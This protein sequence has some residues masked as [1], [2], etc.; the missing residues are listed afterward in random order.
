VRQALARL[1]RRVQGDETVHATLRWLLDQFVVRPHERIAY[2]K[3]PEFTFRF[4]WDDGRLRFIDNGVGRF[5]RA[6]IRRDSLRRLTYDLGLWTDR[7]SP[8]LTGAG[9]AFIHEVLA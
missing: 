3:L 6:G 4:R 2:S 1:N 7:D 9:R 5:R 8:R